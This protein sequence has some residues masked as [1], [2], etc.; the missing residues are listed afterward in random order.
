[1]LVLLLAC[2]PINKLL[3]PSPITPVVSWLSICRPSNSPKLP[4]TRYDQVGV[5]EV[6]RMPEI[7]QLCYIEDHSLRESSSVWLVWSPQGPEISE[8]VSI[9]ISYKVR[10]AR[11][12]SSVFEGEMVSHEDASS[13][14]LASTVAQ[15]AWKATGDG[16]GIV[17]WNMKFGF[18]YHV[19]RICRSSP[20]KLSD[21]GTIL[22]TT[23]IF[24]RFVKIE[25]NPNGRSSETTCTPRRESSYCS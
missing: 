14:I 24:L 6:A 13:S 10:L 20:R 8:R 4:P 12:S 9:I 1:M 25:T 19:T 18:C 3:S 15:L 7:E 23:I 17:W 21:F 22:P 5:P 16:T 11:C 2:L